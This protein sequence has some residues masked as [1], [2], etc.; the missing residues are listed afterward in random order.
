MQKPVKLILGLEEPPCRLVAKELVR[1]GGENPESPCVV[2][3]PT[4]EAAR[5]LK[6]QLA[7]TAAS[8]TGSGAFVSPRIVPVS[9]L[10][11][12]AGGKAAGLAVSLCVWQAIL[13]RSAA[14]ISLL[15]PQTDTW[16]DEAWLHAAKGMQQL[17]HTLAQ[18]GV[19]IGGQAWQKLAAED[20][21]WELLQALHQR[22]LAQLNDRGLVDADF[23][24]ALQVEAGTRVILACV[25]GLPRQVEALLAG[26][27][28]TVEVWIACEEPY[29]AWFDA[30]GRP[31]REWSDTTDRDELGLARADWKQRL[32][33]AGDAWALAAETACAAARANA[34]GDGALHA[35]ALGVCDPDLEPSLAEEFALHGV[36]TYRPE[37]IPFS[38][39]AWRRVLDALS[40]FSEQLRT[41]AADGEADPALLP[42]A[43]LAELLRQPILTRGLGIPNAHLSLR[44]L[45][46][47]RARFLPDRIGFLLK[48]TEGCAE[49][50]QAI[51]ILLPWLQ[52]A[53]GSGKAL[54]QALLALAQAQEAEKD[55]ERSLAEGVRDV[56]ADLLDMGAGRLSTT[57]AILLAGEQLS[58]LAVRGKREGAELSLNGW[59][60]LLYTPADRLVI[61]GM[62]DKQLPERW[63]V[64]PLLTR[65]ARQCLGIRGDDDRAAR[66][67]YILRCLLGSRQPGSV[68][69]VFSR[70]DTRKDPVAPSPLLFTLCPKNRLPEV[71]THFFGKDDTRPCSPSP[72]FDITGWHYLPLGQPDHQLTPQEAAQLRLA[73]L[74]LPNPMHGH[75]FSPSALADFLRCPLRFWLKR[76]R[77][78]KD[79]DADDTR[80][81]LQQRHVGDCLHRV[82]ELFVRRHPSWTSY[83]TEHPGLNLMANETTESVRGDLLAL[84]Q[85][86]Y[87]AEYGS[88][89]LLPQQMQRDN[90]AA[91]L[92]TYAALHVD[93][94]REGWHAAVDRQGTPMVEYQVEWTWNSHRLSMKIDRV[95]ERIAP[96][97]TRSLRIIDYKSGKVDGC[98]KKHLVRLPDNALPPTELEPG[99]I[100]PL[101]YYRNKLTPH[102]WVELQL[103]LYVGWAMQ[104]LP[105]A[106]IYEA[107][108]ICLD[109]SPDDTRI[110]LWGE[111]GERG[112]FESHE[113]TESL[114]DNSARWVKA[115][116]DM[117]SAGQCLASAEQL[118]WGTPSYDLFGE[119]IEH[120]ELQDL[121]FPASS[122]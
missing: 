44:Q 51:D 88:H 9:R 8:G 39:T 107:A 36:T 116:M 42:V 68:S 37:G 6:E 110:I 29:A 11:G 102:R 77:R 94:W 95:D 76:V 120:V 46:E 93:L 47:L 86:I 70:F 58:T 38:A 23:S 26:A 71:V 2:V 50:Q 90:M 24:P 28:L 73:D 101:A 60:E 103:P 35:L 40:E 105:P 4:R 84:F 12:H 14:R 57:G 67:A 5:L 113:Q 87:A 32:I 79:D 25:P 66:D 74:G 118:G 72:A 31:G 7:L 45:K 59:M 15:F 108:Y 122:Q 27:S 19:E 80:E 89:P 17:F 30:W 20:A 34:E 100:P 43:P 61:A 1:R 54:L 99:M 69:F 56:C 13:R 53:L 119:A 96:D 91:R 52:H 82:L 78:I 33:V 109:R 65:A 83:A 10:T 21:R 18:E 41:S 22:Y 106:D 111:G 98:L 92:A 55:A 121:F 81:T 16:G 115:C 49:L 97:G 114:M 112:L 64:H 3:V 104:E 63:P 75:A 117:I 48:K 85:E 62:H